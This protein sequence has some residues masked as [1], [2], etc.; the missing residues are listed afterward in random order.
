VGNA[1]SLGLVCSKMF[2]FP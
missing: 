1:M 2:R